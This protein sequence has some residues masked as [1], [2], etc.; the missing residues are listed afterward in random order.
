MR[1]LPLTALALGLALLGSACD[2]PAAPAKCRGFR[3]AYCA[4]QDEHCD[5]VTWDSCRELFD[6]IVVCDDA[7][8]V[9]DDYSLCLEEIGALDECPVDLPDACKGV[10][11]M[12]EEDDDDDDD[13][14][15]DE[16]AG[17]SPAGDGGVPPFPVGDGGM[18]PGS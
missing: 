7:I 1:A 2:D 18:P 11:L 5:F 3:D 10:V 6:E 8:G 17:P 14:D 15:D 4:K 16:D 9:E 13:D 12:P